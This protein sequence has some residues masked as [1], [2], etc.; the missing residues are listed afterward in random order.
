[1]KKWIL[2]LVIILCMPLLLSCVASP[3]TVTL[4]TTK[5]I[6]SA[7]T[8]T[9]KTTRTVTITTTPV[10]TTPAIPQAVGSVLE[11]KGNYLAGGGGD[12]YWDYF[13]TARVQNLTVD[14]IITVFAEITPKD[15][16][17]EGKNL[18]SSRVYLRQ[19]E[20]KT[21]TFHFWVKWPNEGFDYLVWCGS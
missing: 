9:V 7:P 2:P 16:V 18:Q 13:I 4:T 21:L 19:G 10:I 3:Q 15:M 1:M 17:F 11:F 12:G 20:E 5:V 8:I 14:G 6:T